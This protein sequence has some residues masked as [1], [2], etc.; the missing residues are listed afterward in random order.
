M[1]G[2]DGYVIRKEAL[3]P[4]ARLFL[5]VVN[6]PNIPSKTVLL[7]IK[8]IL[9]SARIQY[10]H[11]T[12]SSLQYTHRGKARFSCRQLFSRARTWFSAECSR[13]NDLSWQYQTNFLKIS[14]YFA[15]RTFWMYFM[16]GK[17]GRYCFTFIS[18]VF[19]THPAHVISVLVGR[20]SSDIFC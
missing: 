19:Q 3:S 1:T 11:L 9:N 5:R 4:H 7:Y 15:M 20:W 6:P 8:Y 12:N 14:W 16:S 17:P 2:N 10:R 13:K 18:P